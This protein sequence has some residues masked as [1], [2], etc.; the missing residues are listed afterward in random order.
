MKTQILTIGC[1]FL[2]ILTFAQESPFGILTK[3]KFV[4]ESKLSRITD[5]EI[6]SPSYAQ[7]YP[8]YKKMYTE[9]VG[10]YQGYR[11]DIVNCVLTQKKQKNF[12]ICIK[13][14]TASFTKALEKLDKFD[15]EMDQKF[16]EIKPVDSGVSHSDSSAVNPPYPK[17][18]EMRIN[19]IV[20]V[21]EGLFSGGIQIWNNAV[22]LENA[23]KKIYTDNINSEP[24]NIEK[25]DKLI[26]KPKK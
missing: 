16:E 3:S 1:I 6:K 24:Y 8:K 10:G 23:K 19:P 9:I 15:N 11:G 26:P 20:S 14:G 12:E 21:I 2:C 25:L 22:S 5:L 4:I 7:L 18:D 17:P 13:P